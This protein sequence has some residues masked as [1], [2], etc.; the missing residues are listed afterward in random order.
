[1]NIQDVGG[2]VENICALMQSEK[3]VTVWNILKKFQEQDS[4]IRKFPYGHV[5]ADSSTDMR[6]GYVLRNASLGDFVVVQTC[7]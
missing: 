3:N 1:V 2:Y 4:P 5:V 7:T 6:R